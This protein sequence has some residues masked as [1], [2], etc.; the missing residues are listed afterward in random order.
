M[1]VKDVLSNMEE[2]NE[3]NKIKDNMYNQIESN[4]LRYLQDIANKVIVPMDSDYS[5]KFI[6]LEIAKVVNEITN[7]SKFLI[8][9]YVSD[10]MSGKEFNRLVL[11]VLAEF[12]LDLATLSII[13]CQAN[14]SIEPRST[15][16][17]RIFP[18]FPPKDKSIGN[19]G[20][21]KSSL[22]NGLSLPEMITQAEKARENVVTTVCQT[23]S[24]GEIG[25]YI[26]KN[27]ENYVICYGFRYLML[28]NYIISPALNVYKMPV[29]QLYLVY[30]DIDFIKGCRHK[31]DIVSKKIVEYYQDQCPYLYDYKTRKYTSS[32]AYVTDIQM[33]IQSYRKGR[34]ISDEEILQTTEEFFDMIHLRYIFNMSVV[35]M[36]KLITL[37]FSKKYNITEDGLNKLH[38]VIE[39]KY[40]RYP[41]VGAPIGI[42]AGT[43]ISEVETQSTLS[44][45][46]QFTKNG[47]DVKST[48]SNTNITLMKINVTKFNNTNSKIYNL[49]S[50]LLVALE[51]I[52]YGLEFI[53]LEDIIL[54]INITKVS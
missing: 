28:S 48:Q 4:R 26:I 54:S 9:Q 10:F 5:N 1:R 3:I 36:L 8:D 39:N 12:K 53:S 2:W 30:L 35:S 18:C 51:R 37:I 46:L 13:Y 25:R 6:K 42:E 31:T 45:H 23:A 29:R 14:P 33:I 7:R 16:L 15:Y 24:K 21:V 19:L 47:C 11:Y 49:T 20:L 50:K 41:E 43:S 44:A 32:V 22:I 40:K 52:K 27:L 38:S 17:H 34:I